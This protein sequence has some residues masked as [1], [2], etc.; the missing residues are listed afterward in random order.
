MVNCLLCS[1]YLLTVNP[2]ERPDIF[3]ASYVAFQI[4]GQPCPVHNL[5]VCYFHLDLVEHAQFLQNVVSSK[6]IMQ[7]AA[8]YVCEI[9]QQHFVFVN[10][11]LLTGSFIII[12]VS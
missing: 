3:Q 9:E 1:E 8:V 4:A 6:L 12:I 7:H 5:H 10:K 11:Y 2:D